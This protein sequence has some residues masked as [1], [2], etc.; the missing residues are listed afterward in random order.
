VTLIE[1]TVREVVL[2]SGLPRSSRRAFTLIE[3]LMVIA[4]IAILAALL[5]PALSSAKAKGRL[6]ACINNLNQLGVSS[7]M[8]SADND[9]KL[10]GNVPLVPIS[11]FG[12]NSWLSGNMT[13]SKDSTNATLIRQGKLFPYASQVATYRCPADTSQ[14]ASQTG[15]SLRVR[16]YSMNGWMGSRYMESFYYG[17]ANYRTFIRESEI[18]AS[19]PS[20]L[21]MIMDEH[22]DSIDDAWFLVT[23]NDSQPF[24]SFPATRHQRGCCLNFADGHVQ[25]FKLRDPN[26]RSPREQAGYMNTDWIRLKQITTTR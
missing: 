26:T 10:V 1:S 20:E 15:G 25:L 14:S 19:S 17:Q 23:M 11:S 12:T 21:W 16:S 13:I 8:Y 24:A 7:Q 5:L 2:Q 22:E 3:L 4:I 6:A 9:G 18:A